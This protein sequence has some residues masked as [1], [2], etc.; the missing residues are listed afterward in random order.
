[1]KVSMFSMPNTQSATVTLFH[2]G[3]DDL[4]HFRPDLQKALDTS[5]SGHKLVLIGV[6]WHKLP[7][8]MKVPELSRGDVS[9]FTGTGGF[10][11]WIFNQNVYPLGLKRVK[12]FTSLRTLS[13]QIDGS[14]TWTEFKP[15]WAS[16]LAK[17]KEL[18]TIGDL[19]SGKL[20]IHDRNGAILHYYKDKTPEEITELLKK[21]SN[22]PI[23]ATGKWREKDSDGALLL[24][25]PEG[26][27][28][29]PH[30]DEATYTAMSVAEYIDGPFT[31]IEMGKGSTQVV[32]CYGKPAADR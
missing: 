16:A 21:H 7:A 29:L 27:I 5:H 23:Y 24:P 26:V 3:Y 18:D 32:T 8:A 17:D 2:K 28:L 14:D 22:V 9:W 25:T 30:I 15:S 1:M 20:S 10:W 11:S 6:P 19:G 12:T 13:R 31:M 4:D